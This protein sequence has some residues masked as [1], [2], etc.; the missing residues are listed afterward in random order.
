MFREGEFR[1]DFQ[2][3]FECS[4]VPVELEHHGLSL[5]VSL[6]RKPKMRL[7]RNTFFAH[8]V[9]TNGTQTKEVRTR[10]CTRPRRLDRVSRRRSPSEAFRECRTVRQRSTLPIPT[11]RRRTVRPRSDLHSPTSVERDCSDLPKSTNLDNDALVRRI[12]N[13]LQVFLFYGTERRFFARFSFRHGLQGGGSERRSG[14]VA[15][16]VGGFASVIVRRTV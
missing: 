5:S 6:L 3:V 1:E 9:S 7:S 11:T 10:R 2:R 14:T 15:R 13:R 4:L 16:L 12:S 8:R